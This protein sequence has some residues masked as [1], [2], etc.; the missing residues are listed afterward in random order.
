[1]NPTLRKRSETQGGL[2]RTAGVL[3]G[4]FVVVIILFFV[5]SSFGQSF[6]GKC[7]GVV[8]IDQEISTSG[9]PSTLFSSGSPGSEEISNTIRSLNSR[10]DMSSVVFVMNSPGGSVVATREI[11][12][13]VKSLNKPKVAYF[14]EVSASGSYYI[15]TGTDYII[16][17]PDAITGSIGVIATFTQMGG[18]LDKLGINS[19]AI[20]SGQYKDIGSPYRNMTEDE[21]AIVQSMIDEIYGEFRNVVITNRGSRLNIAKFNEVA[22]GRI[23]SGRQAQKVGLVDELG[24]KRDAIMKAANLSN[25][26]YNNYDD[27][28]ICEVPL[29]QNQGGLFSADS[30]L[31]SFFTKEQG[32]KLSY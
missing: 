13:S 3:I 20:K 8:N 26:T 17:D 28:K 1:M 21:R 23:L 16:S 11:Y 18:L 19:T 29:S 5:F 22:D 32:V 12:D 15:S 25:M 27:I 4:A 14:R 9:V 24:S 2:I 31:R 6:A 10:P 7:V 30:I